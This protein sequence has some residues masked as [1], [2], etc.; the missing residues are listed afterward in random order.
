MDA[1]DGVFEAHDARIGPR[2]RWAGRPLSSLAAHFDALV[3]LVTRE[4]RPFVPGGAD[5]LETDDI[6]TVFGVAP[7]AAQAAAQLGALATFRS[8][9]VVG[10]GE[11]A[12]TLTKRL[13]VGKD[14]VGLLDPDRAS[15]RHIARTLPRVPVWHGDPS[16]PDTR[17]QAGIEHADVVACLLPEP[18]RVRGDALGPQIDA[19]E[20]PLRRLGSLRGYSLW[21]LTA[22]PGGRG[23][24]I[25]LHRVACPRGT[26][27]VG[28]SRSGHAEIARGDTVVQAGDRLLV[29]ADPSTTAR[30]H[31]LFRSAA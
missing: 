30:T 1:L 7:S 5:C 24:G 12:L 9:R 22:Q 13:A 19:D 31:R 25:P 3:G 10:S 17:A 28:R 15:S 4:G 14:D 21:E 16:D 2:C 29:L 23:L 26:L 8:L 11:A 18:H 20:Q 6:V 27:V